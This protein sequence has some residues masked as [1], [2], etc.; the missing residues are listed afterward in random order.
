MASD[1]TMA[2][3]ALAAIDIERASLEQSIDEVAPPF[4]YV[5]RPA[6]DASNLEL[7]ALLQ[8]QAE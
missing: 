7:P 6:P 5:V 3:R 2:V 1:W 8:V 4:V